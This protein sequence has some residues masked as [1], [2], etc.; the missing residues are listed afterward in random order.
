MKEKT[1][2]RLPSKNSETANGHDFTK[3]SIYDTDADQK[4]LILLNN[5]K[6]F[7]RRGPPKVQ[8]TTDEE[9]KEGDKI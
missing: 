9:S 5:N 8:S 3:Y 1:L 6:H 2:Q 4:D 7:D